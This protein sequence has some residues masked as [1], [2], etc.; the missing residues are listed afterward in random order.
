MHLGNSQFEF[1]FEPLVQIDSNPY[2][3]SYISSNHSM[4]PCHDHASYCCIALI[5][6]LLC[7]RCLS[8][9]SRSCSDDVIDD[10]DEELLLSSEV[11]GKQPPLNIPLESHSLALALFYCI[12]TTTFQLLHA[13]VA[14]PPF[15]CMTYP[16]HSKQL[17]PTSM[18]RICLSHDV[19]T[20]LCFACYACYAQSCVRSDSSGM[21]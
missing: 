20:H 4:L 18:S 17:K 7:C 2:V 10:T 13:A 16:C 5:V 15:L 12:R 9:L 1:E 19:P 14:E 3:A 6:F 8:P 21:D 11:P